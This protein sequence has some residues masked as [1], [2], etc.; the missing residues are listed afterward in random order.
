MQLDQLAS[1]DDPEAPHITGPFAS[2]FLEPFGEQL[3][4]W[5]PR[6]EATNDRRRA[7]VGLVGAWR[8]ILGNELQ[9]LKSKHQ[10]E[11]NLHSRRYWRQQL[12]V[13]ASRFDPQSSR[14]D[15][16]IDDEALEEV[17]HCQAEYDTWRLFEDLVSVRHPETNLVSSST[18]TPP[19]ADYGN[20]RFAADG[21]TFRNY[22]LSSIPARER[23]VVCKWLE[24]SSSNSYRDIEALRAELEDWS[25]RG[26]SLWAS[27]WMDTRERIKAEKRLR[28]WNTSLDDLPDVLGSDGRPVVQQLDPDARTRLKRS[29]D[30]QDQSF[31]IAFWRMCLEMVRQGASMNQL[32]LLCEECN[33]YAMAVL[34]GAAFGPQVDFDAHS[35]VIARYKWRRACS[36][37]NI[38]RDAASNVFEAALLGILGGNTSADERV[39]NE[40]KD[41]CHALTNA[42]LVSGYQDYVREHLL[43]TQRGHDQLR[44]PKARDNSRLN[45]SMSNIISTVVSDKR[46]RAKSSTHSATACI[47]MSILSDNLANTLAEQGLLLERRAAA[48]TSTL[49]LSRQQTGKPI[50]DD[51]QALRILAHVFIIS[52]YLGIQYG[53]EFE[54]VQNERVAQNICAAYAQHLFNTGK[55][56]LIPLYACNLS[57]DLAAHVM[58]KTMP[59]MLTD[60]QRKNCVRMMEDCQMDVLG[61][62][63]RQTQYAIEDLRN[64]AAVSEQKLITSLELLQRT[65]E[66]IW[67]NKRIAV[68]PATDLSGNDDAALASAQ[69]YLYVSGYWAETFEA[70]LDI[71]ETFLTLGKHSAAV[72]FAQEMSTSAMIENKWPSDREEPPDV[73]EEDLDPSSELFVLQQQSLM[74][75]QCVQLINAISALW[76]WRVAEERG[77]RQGAS[78][79]DAE[80]NMYNR[81]ELHTAIDNLGKS[82]DP[83]LTENFLNFPRNEPTLY[84]PGESSEARFARHTATLQSIRE[85]HLPEIIL[86]FNSSLTCAGWYVSR[87]SF[88]DSLELGRTISENDELVRCF[89]KAERMR[90]LVDALALTSKR[91]LLAN[92]NKG[93][94]SKRRGKTRRTLGIWDVRA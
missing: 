35:C 26:K 38:Q 16:I 47:Q 42:Q 53:S 86:A 18:T 82:M 83:V 52:K 20:D 44:D 40:W 22:I 91:M 17:W 79:V 64:E 49:N 55:W 4:Q 73:L 48:D 89:Q 33:Q 66:E 67:P 39:C 61:V 37:A 54:H 43:V 70:L 30:S 77:L 24:E 9:S 59:V 85:T 45:Q 60:E 3:D 15:A 14:E 10:H 11:L 27:E 50:I 90:E 72:V 29:V 34:M 12:Q 78:N 81:K 19:L 31:D 57:E 84:F 21:E 76:D 8:E 68:P 7:A 69:W 1:R 5:R 92:E 41:L 94:G 62:L 65:E 13:D 58:A 46:M 63:T 28:L 71:V 87:D 56:Q 6:S 23:L 25:R 75:K 32:R 93:Q 2:P 74:Y 51:S 88:I 80:R 36:V